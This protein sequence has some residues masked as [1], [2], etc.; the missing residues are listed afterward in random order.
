MKAF[1][2]VLT[3]CSAAYAQD[4]TRQL[5]DENILS[6]R[7]AAQSHSTPPAAPHTLPPAVSKKLE[8]AGDAF[9][10]VTLWELLPATARPGARLLVH[11]D[12]RDLKVEYV[13]VRTSSMMQIHPGQKI[14]LSIETARAGYLYV[15]D[16]EKYA[17]GS[18]SD[19]Y[20]IFPTHRIRGG[21]N[22]IGPGYVIEIPGSENPRP[23]FTFRPNYV[24]DASHSPQTD[25]V[26]T[27]LVAPQ[28]LPG[29]EIGER[30]VKLSPAQLAAWQKD[31]GGRSERLDSDKDAG[32]PYTETEKKAGQGEATLTRQDAAPATLFHLNAGADQPLLVEFPIAISK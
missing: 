22:R 32:K 11:E 23:Y 29:I 2:L 3:I 31:F 21:Q 24:S 5:W 30:E 8:G 12:D 27:I 20:V 17:D 9:V 13:P 1:L 19:P 16:R 25:E 26:L 18:Y 15:I 10:G 6:R 4:A 14:R 7:P 28:A